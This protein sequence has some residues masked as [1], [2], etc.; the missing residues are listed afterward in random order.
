MSEVHIRQARKGRGAVHNPEVRFESLFTVPFDDGWGTLDMEPPPPL[1]TALW[2]DRAKTVI[3]RNQ[4]PDIPFEQS[5][6]PYRGCEHGCIYCYARPSH[7]FL[8]LSPGLDFETQLFRKA[9]AA[10][11][12]SKELRKKNY[13]PKPITI[14]S[15]TDPYQPVE[16]T[17]KITRDVLKVLSEFRHPAAII[18]KSA[19]VLRDLD[20]LADLANDQ[21]IMVVVSVTTLDAKLAHTMEPRAAAP[22]R[23]I[24]TIRKLAGA[25]IPVSVNAAPMIPALNDHELEQIM[26]AGVAAGARSAAYILLR[27]PHEVRD[28]FVDWLQAHF[29]DRAQHVMSLIRQARGGKDYVAEFGTRMRGTG[30]YAE[31]LRKRYHVAKERL[32]LSGRSFDL[33]CQA[34]KVPPSPNDQHGAGPH[35]SDQ[36]RGGQLSLFEDD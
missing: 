21:L 15:N 25:G 20:L 5:F 17:Q 3:T 14:G 2:E 34:F 7:A 10:Q 27:L 6:N 24:E 28:L 26:E 29:P 35:G 33:N 36:H 18:T 9:N 22:H 1:K 13:K 11:L 8:G 12:L 19:L 31:L 30:A 4:S 16:R 32:G 23:R